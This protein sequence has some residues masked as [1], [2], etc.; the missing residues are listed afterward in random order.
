MP[1]DS[2]TSHAL[3]R[4]RLAVVA[5]ALLWSTSGLFAKATIFADWPP[6]QRGLLL[7]F[8]RALFGGLVLLP[9]VRRPRWRPAL[10]PMALVFAAMNVSYLSAVVLTTAANAIWLQMT[11]PAWVMVIGVTFLGDR[12]TRVERL[13]LALGVAG[14]AVI[15][16]SLNRA[17]EQLPHNAVGV[18][19]ALVSGITYAGVVMFLRRLREE[20]A[21]W[22]IALNLLVTA[23]LLLPY[24]VYVAAVDG[25]YPSTTQF[26]ILVAFGGLQIGLPYLLFAYGLKNISSQEA[27]GLALLE[28]VL[29][30][31]W[32][33]LAWAEEPAPATVA[34]A[35]LILCGLV[36]RYGPKSRPPRRVAGRRSP[37]AA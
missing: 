9:T 15:L 31:L 21:A 23:A 17:T 30:P 28:P 32:V 25:R 16:C 18:A 3:F 7:A 24:V 34:G 35:A 36:V 19:M 37:H 22:L 29:M 13:Q 14:V 5:A 20:N 33:W 4:A 8:W 6:E 2:S 27:A 11:S 26:A 1:T 10:V 12:P